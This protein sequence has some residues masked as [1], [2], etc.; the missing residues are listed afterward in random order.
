MSALEEHDQADVKEEASCAGSDEVSS[1]TVQTSKHS[2]F[3]PKEEKHKGNEMELFYSPTLEQMLMSPP[4]SLSC[5]TTAG[6]LS[7]LAEAPPSGQGLADILPTSFLSQLA[8]QLPEGAGAATFP[9][10]P[11]GLHSSPSDTLPHMP[12]ALSQQT[13]AGVSH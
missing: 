9:Y 2:S 12:L 13:S 3:P 4:F 1:G 7:S 10:L 8:G 6:V 5:G 11:I